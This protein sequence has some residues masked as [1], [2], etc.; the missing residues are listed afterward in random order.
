MKIFGYEITKVRKIKKVIIDTQTY[1][2]ENEIR[3]GGDGR[4]ISDGSEF[5]PLITS[6]FINLSNED[7]L[8]KMTI[9][10]KV[11]ILRIFYKDFCEFEII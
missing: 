4:F 1:K 6:H 9:E 10:Q 11:H 7:V 8:P 5:L 2:P 3:L